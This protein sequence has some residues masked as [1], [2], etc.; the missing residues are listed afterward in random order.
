V[1][2]A[3]WLVGLVSGAVFALGLC[4]SGMTD[5]GKVLAFLD[6]SGSWDPTLLAVMGGAVGFHFT[7][8]RLSKTDADAR[9]ER[10][11]IDHRLLAGAIIFGVG[12]GLSGY[13]PGPA[14]VSAAFGRVEALTFVGAMLL[15]MKLLHAFDKRRQAA[16]SPAR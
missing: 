9:T 13:C 7:A 11:P 6:V 5:P 10:R 1:T 3:P 2:R 12:W 14:L 8:L 16:L 15:G 4:V